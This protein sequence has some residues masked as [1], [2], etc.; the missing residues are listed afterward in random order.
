M[1]H[2]GAV[3]LAVLERRCR[4][5]VGVQCAMF[6][7]I[8][9]TLLTHWSGTRLAAQG[10]GLTLSE[11]TI[12]DAQGTVRARIGGDLP[13][14][15]IDGKPVPRGERA[16]GVLLY[17]DTGAER[18]GYVTFASPNRNVVLTLDNDRKQTAL[19]GAGPDGGSALRL[20]YEDNAVELNVGKDGPVI[21]A[22]ENK[23][24][25]FHEPAVRNPEHTELCQEL[26]QARAKMSDAQLLEI[27]VNRSSE[28]A[29]RA[30]LSKK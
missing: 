22:T 7:L 14:A 20:W 19:F 16:A 12:V 24:A 2:E 13:D 8:A 6:L 27:C 10:A 18:S 21:H 25:A 17:D 26:R 5:L 28:A 4:F 23:R 3:R 9:A 30:C 11:L 1:T 15:V 29:C